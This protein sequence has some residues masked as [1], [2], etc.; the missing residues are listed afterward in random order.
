V[1][2]DPAQNPGYL[3]LDLYCRGIRIGESCY[4]EGDGGRPLVRTRAGLGSGLELVLPGDLWTNVPV[5]EE[6][7][8]GTPYVLEKRNGRYVVE[9]EGKHTAHVDLAPQPAWYERR[10]STG[11]VM[12]SVGTLQG[13]Y[14]GVYPAKVCEYWLVGEKDPSGGQR[15]ER[16]NCRF[17]SVGLN[18]GVDDADG[19]SVQEVLEVVRAAWLESGITYVDFNTGHYT[20]H[21]FLD[22]LEPYI[23]A[24]KQETGLL[25]G[26]QTPP[27]PDLTRYDRLRELGVNRVSF[28]FEIFDRDRFIEVC[29]GKHE[30]Y[31]LDTY[32]AAV[33]YCARLGRDRTKGPWVTNGELIA[34][35]E[36]PESTMRAIDWLTERGAIPT[37]CVFRPLKGTD[38]E[39]MPAPQTDDLVPVFARLYEKCMEHGLPIGIAPNVHVSLVMLPEEGRYLV[40]DPSRFRLGE[41]KLGL[42]KMAFRTAFRWQQRQRKQAARHAPVAAGG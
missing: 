11:R 35:L 25:I 9:R 3:K 26:V 1:I 19:K 12:R 29:P 6:F 21:T 41:W 23:R 2:R 39:N 20:G 31:G 32:L 36:P 15:K 13:T 28:C 22:I 27:H 5:V 38:Y 4:L 16:T 37:I 18:L 33:E 30:A 10:T 40:D 7:V 34:G 17:C 8:K 42:Q 14:L 24:I